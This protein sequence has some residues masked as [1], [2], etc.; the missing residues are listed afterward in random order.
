MAVKKKV[1]FV[2]DD[3]DSV[4]STLKMVLEG[5]NK[6]EVFGETR[7]E[8][9][10]NQIRQNKPDLVLLDIHMPHVDGSQIAAQM[11]A[12]S[13]LKNIPVIFLTGIITKEESKRSPVQGTAPVLAKPVALQEI[14]DCIEKQLSLKP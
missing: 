2:L 13:S 3:E 1:I 11:K 5:T 10:L 9:A 14:L 4:V 12:D 8:N 7:S 6:Y